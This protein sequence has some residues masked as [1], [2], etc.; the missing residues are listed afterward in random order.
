M[1]MN[2]PTVNLVSGRL[3]ACDEETCEIYQEGSWKHLQNTTA[4]RAFH[5]S[6]TTA[7]AVL[8]I[9]GRDS[10]STEL[11]PV[12]GSSAQ[13]GPFTIRHGSSHCTIQISDDVIV[14]TGGWPT[15]DYV[16]EYQLANGTETPLT[17]LGEP[18]YDHAC[19]AYK[20]KD[21]LQ[22]RKKALK[23][24]CDVFELHSFFNF[25]F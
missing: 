2:S 22:V 15:L 18:R 21:G 24:Q 14:V 1:F 3:V 19:G 4:R 8:L 11:I 12:D 5:S 20:D 17:S 10:N 6:A 13:Q 9:G 16:T 23:L 7:D 25:F